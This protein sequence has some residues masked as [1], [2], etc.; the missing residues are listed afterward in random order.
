MSKYT[1]QMETEL[2]SATPITFEMAS[3]FAE[4]WADKDVT[5]KSIVAKCK[6]LG[7]DYIPKAKAVRKTAGITKAQ[8]VKRIEAQ[9]NLEQDS[10]SGL[11]NATMA[12]LN[13]LLEVIA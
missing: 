11:T 1:T 12:S 6:S 10:L 13:T 5:V 9:M 8:L 4:K 3:A 7:L 2:A